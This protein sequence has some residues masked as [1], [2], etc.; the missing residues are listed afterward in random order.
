MCVYDTCTLLDRFPYTG[1][2]FGK[3]AC[4][5]I[6]RNRRRFVLADDE[7]GTGNNETNVTGLN[8]VRVIFRDTGRA[9]FA[10]SL[11]TA[12]RETPLLPAV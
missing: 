12:E 2:T 11:R 6:E 9:Q 4:Y 1:G 3:R 7:N 8:G 10:N 5:G